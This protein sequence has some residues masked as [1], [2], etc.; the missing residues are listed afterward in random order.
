MRYLCLFGAFLTMSLALNGAD[1]KARTITFDKADVDKLPKGWTAAQTGKGDG[2]VWK[3]VADD[4]AP[5]RKGYVLAQTTE[6]PKAAFN[7]CV[8]DDSKYKDVDIRVAF[9][10]VKGKI[11]Q[12]GG[13]VW[14]YQ[15]ANNYF[16][17]RY[18]P[19]E[20]NL[21][22]YKVVDGGR[23]QLATK[24]DLELKAGAWHTFQVAMEGERVECKLNGKQV[25]E[26]KDG[27][28]AKPGK[29]GLWTK[30]DAQ[31]YFDDLKI[32]GK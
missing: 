21:R 10:A 1:D 30:A 11:D 3:V 24:E 19:L 32:S 27:T 12:G 2:S 15:D 18:N 29:V 4:S 31:T 7:L 16:V 13:V 20:G 6:G 23:T 25:F 9:K 8:L 17:A 28:I 14:R 22:F 5:T 26:A